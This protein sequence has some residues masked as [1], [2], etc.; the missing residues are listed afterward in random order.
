MTQTNTA[1]SI[2]CVCVNHGTAYAWQYVDRL[3]G[4]LQRHLG[5]I[6]F[7][8]FTEKNRAVPEHMIKHDLQ[9]WP[10]I[11][12]QKKAWWYKLQ[13]FDADQLPGQNL[14]FDLDTVVIDDLSWILKLDSKYF[15]T[16]RD[17]RYLWKPQWQGLNSSLMYWNSTEFSWIWQDLCQ[18]N[19]Q[20]VSRQFRGD[21]DY[22]NALL[23]R[24]QIKFI[25]PC[26]VK[27]WRWQVHDG[28][29]DASMNQYCRPGAGAVIPSNTKIIVFHGNP[30]PHNIQDSVILQHWG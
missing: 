28:G 22:L 1:Q 29:L 20:A 12:G 6:K 3:Y 16:I 15:W 2:N 10:G 30:K 8:V 21:Q 5:N 24:D 27:S 9:E 13:M 19:I 25:D 18:R 14:Y 11:S 4:M 17:F 26:Y 23:H 7:H